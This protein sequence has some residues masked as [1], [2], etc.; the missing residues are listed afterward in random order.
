MEQRRETRVDINVHFFVSIHESENEPDMVGMSL[1][2]DTIDFSAHGMQFSTNSELSA[3]T[4][5]NITI[6]IGEPFAMYLLRGEVRWV[7]HTD[8]SFFMGI[9]LLAVEDTDIIR[10]QENF[11]DLLPDRAR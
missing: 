6:G 7:R 1:E 10:W 11:E 5:V 3:G 8:E 9:L 2:C 4:K